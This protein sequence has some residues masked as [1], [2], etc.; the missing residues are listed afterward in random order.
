MRFLPDGAM[1][2]GVLVSV[3]EI[4]AAVIHVDD[5]ATAGAKN[6]TSWADAFTRLQDALA[7][8]VAGDEIRVATG[9]YA[10]ADAPGTPTA[11]FALVSGVTVQGGFAGLNAPGGNPDELDPLSYPTVLTGDLAGDDASNFTNYSENTFHVVTADSTNESTQLRGVIIRG[12]SADDPNSPDH[13]VGGA[14]FGTGGGTLLAVQC[15]LEDNLAYY[16]GAGVYCSGIDGTFVIHMDQ[17]IVQ[18]NENLSSTAGSVGVAA[19]AGSSFLDC[20]FEENVGVVASSAAAIGGSNLTLKSCSFIN[21]AAGEDG[22]ALYG[23]DLTISDCVFVGNHA[24]YWGTIVLSGG[25]SQIAECSFESN[26]TGVEGGAIMVR[27][28]AHVTI[29]DCQF[30]DNGATIGG[31]LKVDGTAAILR[32]TFDENT[33]WENYGYNGGGIAITGHVDLVNCIFRANASEIGGGAISNSGTLAA[34]NCMF[35]G[36]LTDGPG[37]AVLAYVNA[38][39]TSLTNC[40]IVG[41]SAEFSAAISAGEGSLIL[42]NCIV[43]NN[44]TSGEISESTQIDVVDNEVKL[45][46]NC[47]TGWSGSLGGEGNF[48]DDPQFIDADGPDNAYGT[49]DDNPRL[50][51]ASPCVDAGDTSLLPPDSFDLDSDSQTSE[52]I[53]LDLDD[54]D[55]TRGGAVD[56]GAFEV[57]NCAA[58]I[59]PGGGDGVVNNLD[60]QLMAASWGSCGTEG[61]PADIAPPGGDGIVGVDDLMVLVHSWGNCE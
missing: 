10:P 11:T 38:D 7:V 19:G 13:G 32:C 39:Q 8:A 14:I 17:C 1:T 43:W 53:P 16:G 59:A 5:S 21:N 37:S 42:N 26:T 23:G 61:C 20:V 50:T 60:L 35:T 4:S 15:V 45:N 22:A 57:Q 46:H 29:I 30:L 41:N 12:G 36:N 49:A 24:G 52:L 34:A 18:R 31:A 44:D 3:T 56:A 51:S 2:L 55:R 28:A 40:T 25:I 33:T 47:I 48:G 54:N 6:G 9:S 58:D 27:N